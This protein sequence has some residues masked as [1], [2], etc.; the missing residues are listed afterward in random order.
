V[1][2]SFPAI[3]KQTY[4]P[5]Q[6]NVYW[7]VGT[8]KARLTTTLTA[9]VRTLLLVPGD[10]RSLF[11]EFERVDRRAAQAASLFAINQHLRWYSHASFQYKT[12]PRGDTGGH[13]E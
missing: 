13:G 10:Q 11:R 2:S 6:K 3:H 7:P 5:K 12:P 4:D 8:Q 1:W 9:C